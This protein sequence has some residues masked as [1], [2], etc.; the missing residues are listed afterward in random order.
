R[1]RWSIRNVVEARET[2]FALEL[3]YLLI[4]LSAAASYIEGVYTLPNNL[5]PLSLAV[6]WF[7]ALGGRP[8]LLTGTV[9][10]PTTGTADSP[11][12]TS[13][14]PLIGAGVAIVGVLIMQAGLAAV[15]TGPNPDT[16]GNPGAPLQEPLL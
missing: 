1:R 13:R 4:L 7:D 2:I 10:T 11:T 14:G 8:H 6:L 3:L 12:G 16:V 9:H 15:G 5:G